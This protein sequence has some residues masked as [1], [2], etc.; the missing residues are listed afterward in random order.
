MQRDQVR[1]R[2]AELGGVRVGVLDHQ[3]NIERERAGI[4]HGAHDDGT[5]GQVRHEVAVHDVDV[6]PVRTCVSDGADLVAQA[7]KVSGQDGRRDQR[8]ECHGAPSQAARRRRA[9][10]KASMPCA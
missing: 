8:A 10:K 5:E 3:V 9:A 2:V 6:D 4:A 1:A 7:A